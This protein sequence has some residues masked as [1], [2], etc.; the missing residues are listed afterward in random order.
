MRRVGTPPEAFR[1]CLRCIRPISALQHWGRLVAAP[2]GTARRDGQWRCI[3]C[4]FWFSLQALSK[5]NKRN[6]TFPPTFLH[7]RCKN[8]HKPLC[9]SEGT[10]NTKFSCLKLFFVEAVC[11]PLKFLVD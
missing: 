11:A 3:L 5:K 7:R 10:L 1:L 9:I 8:N 4:G 2:G 6:K